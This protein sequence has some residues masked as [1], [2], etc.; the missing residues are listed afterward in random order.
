MIRKEAEVR[1]E[2]AAREVEVKALKAHLPNY[3]PTS[4]T[5]KAFEA[6]I[7]AHETVINTLRWTLGESLLWD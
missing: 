2:I 3:N 1:A 6:T 7:K 5:A 4:E